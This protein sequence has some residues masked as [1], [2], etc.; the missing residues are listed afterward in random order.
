VQCGLIASR[1]VALHRTLGIA[2]AGIAVLMAISGIWGALIAASRPGGFIAVSAPPLMFLVEPFFDIVM[3][4]SLVGLALI[5]RRDAA[6]HKRLMLLGSLAMV[7]AAAARM[8]FVSAV[9]P[10]WGPVA[11]VVILV[12]ALAAYDLSARG[13]PHPVT[14]WAGGG[15][16]LSF[17]LRLWIGASTTWQYIAATA[18]DW[19]R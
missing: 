14:L 8:P 5:W 12:L 18:V 10:I 13:R 2:G 9:H 19:A 16:I 7:D 3:F 4:A 15:L 17:P 6:T 1:R 11:M